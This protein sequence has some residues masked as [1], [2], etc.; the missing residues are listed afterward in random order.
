MSNQTEE[1]LLCVRK[2][3]RE[4]FGPYKDCGRRAKFYIEGIHAPVLLCGM[5]A[6]ASKRRGA[7]LKPISDL[8]A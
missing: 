7:K 8:L 1:T 6:N 2:I 3:W 5:H 4:N